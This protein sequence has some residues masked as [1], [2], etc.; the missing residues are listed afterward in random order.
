M[1]ITPYTVAPYSIFTVNNH[2]KNNP[3]ASTAL[4]YLHFQFSIHFTVVADSPGMTT[5]MQSITPSKSLP[6]TPNL[7]LVHP[8]ES[9]SS[10]TTTMA[11]PFLEE[12]LSND[13]AAFLDNPSLKA[14]LADG[15]LDLAS[16]SSTVEGELADCELESKCI[17]AYREKVQ[18]IANL[19]K[20]SER[21]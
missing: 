2:N 11:Q 17:D 18:D 5:S 16:Y 1:L 10:S 15:S 12:Q 7:A 20:K 13:L 9:S 6:S 4:H 19:A 21:L 14:A 8:K 3:R